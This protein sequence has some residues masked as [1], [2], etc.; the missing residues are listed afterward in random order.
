[1]R[2]VHV[3]AISPLPPVATTVGMPWDV[4]V[5]DPVAALAEARRR[6]GDTLVVD[7][8]EDRFL[9]TFSPSGVVAFYAL[10]EERASKAVA[11]WRM[12]RRKLPDEIFSGR[13][14]LP[15]QLFGRDDVADYLVHVDEA[16]DAAFEE[17]GPAGEIEVFDFTRRLG[18]RTGLASWGGPGAASGIRFARLV[19]AFDTLDGAESFVH[20]DSMAAVAASGK[21]GR[22]RRAGGRRRRDRRALHELPGHEPE[23]ALFSRVAAAWAGEPGD[24]GPLGVA[25]DVALI[26]V[27]SMSNLFAALGWML[28]DLVTHPDE[29]AAGPGRRPRPGRG[30]G[31]GVDPDG[32]T[33]DHGPLRAGAGDRRR[34]RRRLRGLG[35]RHRRHAPAPHE[36]ERGAGAA[37]VRSPIA[38]TGGAWR[39]PRRWGRSSW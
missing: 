35:R 12:L 15:H 19:D 23:H 16:L 14:S 33:V 34:R 11:D 22:A 36:H 7:S 6:L 10:A 4:E 31:P 24:E 1:M 39:T 8:G 5:E 30:V 2:A 26:H 37:V 38:G 9:F 27:A 13:R 21:A 18:H 17:L 20:P 32:A 3:P 28:V 29:L 25:M